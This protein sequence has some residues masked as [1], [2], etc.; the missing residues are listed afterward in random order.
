V[1]VQSSCGK[2]ANSGGF[3]G[4]DMASEHQIC[5]R[6]R[7]CILKCE[8]CEQIKDGLSIIL[9]FGLLMFDTVPQVESRIYYLSVLC[10]MIGFLSSGCDV[11]GVWRMVMACL[12]VPWAVLGNQKV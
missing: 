12:G 1:P 7:D 8:M 10:S 4:V 3:D 2:E 9:L 6:V 5:Q 11:S